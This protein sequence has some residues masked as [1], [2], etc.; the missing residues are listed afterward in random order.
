MNVVDLQSDAVVVTETDFNKRAVKL[1]SS[2]LAS[3]RPL[4]A[5]VGQNSSRCHLD[6]HAVLSH[7]SPQ[8]PIGR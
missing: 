7:G 2:R 5:T 8:R 3:N 6:A 1:R 4:R